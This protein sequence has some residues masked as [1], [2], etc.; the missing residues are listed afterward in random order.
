[1]AMASRF[2]NVLTDEV[3][4]AAE[5]VCLA[6]RACGMAWSSLYDGCSGA[7]AV[8]EQVG[9]AEERKKWLT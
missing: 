3:L 7:Y 9:P 1:M 6:T 2:S 8:V 4:A 5:R